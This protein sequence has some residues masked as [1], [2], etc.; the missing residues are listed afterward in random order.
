MESIFKDVEKLINLIGFKEIQVS[1]DEERRRISLIVD[2]KLVHENMGVFLS[3]LDHVLGLMFRKKKES[4]FVL[5]VNYYR[6]ERERLIEELARAAAKKAT[7]TKTNIELPAMNSYERRIVHVE[8][9]THPEL[10]TESTGEGK[11]RRVIVK[12]LEN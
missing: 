5:D 6:R 2:D 11:E 8:I 12:R 9:A 7:I 10:C 3:S 1:F 4:P